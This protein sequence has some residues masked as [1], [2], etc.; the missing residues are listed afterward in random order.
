M[1]VTELAAAAVKLCVLPPAGLLLLYGLGLLLGRWR[2]RLATWLRHGSVAMLYF[3]ATGVASWLLVHPLEQLEPVL[4]AP[5]A[6]SAGAIVVLSA[7]R[8][9]RSPE[10]A[11]RTIPDFIALTRMN[12]AALLARQ[13]GLPL[14]VTGGVLSTRADDEALATAM[15]RVF[16][17]HY[18]LPVRWSET[19][20]RTTAENALYSARLLRAA[21]ITRIVLVTDAMHMRRARLA[22]EREGMQVIPAPTMYAETGNFNALRWFPTAENVRRTHYALYEW[23]GLA[24]YSLPQ[25]RAR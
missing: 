21:G 5:S 9:R 20:S 2:P 25:R 17:T 10:Y 12:Y 16:E 19:V 6:S 1:S 24:L 23:L 13:T 4:R 15:K 14:L 18:G 8:I 7:S 11:G 3:L 22:F